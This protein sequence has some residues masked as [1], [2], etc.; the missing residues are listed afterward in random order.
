MK[1]YRCGTTLSEISWKKEADPIFHCGSCR[2]TRWKHPLGD[3]K[4]NWQAY[5]RAE[6]TKM[7]GQ[8]EVP[9]WLV[10]EYLG[11]RG[12][13]HGYQGEQLGHWIN[14]E[15]NHLKI[16]DRRSQKE[17]ERE[18]KRLEAADQAVKKKK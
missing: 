2:T 12:R 14:G 15:Q 5:W 17:Q 1:C 8:G 10:R 4:E 6:E 11:E 16:V 18:A 13:T 9:Y 7:L 3:V